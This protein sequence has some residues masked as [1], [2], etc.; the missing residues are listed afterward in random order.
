M[1]KKL[2]LVT[3]SRQMFQHHAKSFWLASFF[4]PS[5][6]RDD[7]AVVYSFCRIVDDAVDEAV[8]ST[9]GGLAISKIESELNGE[10][11]PRPIIAGFLKIIQNHPIQKY[12][13][14]DLIL[15]VQTDV[16]TVRISD[17]WHLAQ[18]CYR[19]AGSVGLMMC[20]V[21]G[22]NNPKAWPFAIDLGIAMQLT[23]ICRDVLE[24]ARNDRVYLPKSRLEKINSSHSNVL[25]ESISFAQRTV[26]VGELLD[27]ADVFYKRGIC[28]MHYIPFRT[29]A[30]IV[31]AS[32][33]YRA[34]GLKLRNKHKNDP[35][36]GRTIV[37]S[38]HK[39]WHVFVSILIFFSPTV[40]GLRSKKV[41]EQ[42]MFTDWKSISTFDDTK[43]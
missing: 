27:L 38:F 18:Y 19:V 5:K 15:G 23:N 12:A 20:G 26:V 16:S 36:H 6:C 39:I 30:A 31:V 24:D 29:R 33:L 32:Q 10:S 8:D 42:T 1:T 7:S 14:K 2:D 37:Y 22:I 28:G 34:I 25:D 11:P 43:I 3:H 21:L 35:F 13:A 9:Q 40:L 41:P 4:L 17:D